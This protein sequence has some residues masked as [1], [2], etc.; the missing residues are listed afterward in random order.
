[1]AALLNNNNNNQSGRSNQTMI[2]GSSKGR[3]LA[4]EELEGIEDPT[5]RAREASREL[6]ASERYQERVRGIR[7]DAIA[8]M[9]R[10]LAMKS[11]A[12]AQVLSMSK[13]QVNVIMQ[14]KAG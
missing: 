8:Q 3:R 13:T 1:V 12:I 14:K 4:L 6:M 10:C 9:A 2:S 11:T 5:Q 7:N